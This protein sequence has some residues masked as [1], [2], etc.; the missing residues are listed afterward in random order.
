MDQRSPRP[1]DRPDPGDADEEPGG[2]ALVFPLITLAGFVGA[3]GL[4]QW[5]GLFVSFMSGN[6]VALG[7]DPALGGWRG[8]WEAGRAVLCFLLGAIIGELIGSAART[9]RGSAVVGTEAALLWLALASDLRGWDGAMTVALTGLAMGVQT[10][11]V[12]RVAGTTV[13][14][15]YVTGTLV[16]LGRGIAAALRGAAPWRRILPFAGSW[17]ALLVG[18]A[19]GGVVARIATRDALG[20]AAAMASAL[21]LLSAAGVAVRHRKSVASRLSVKPH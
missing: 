12:Q 20:V 17:L 16:S 2:C 21:A 7:G 1:A 5:H 9:W 19:A 11:A 10:A 4:V 18:S 3:L 13:A 8:A 15:T 14:L 6:T